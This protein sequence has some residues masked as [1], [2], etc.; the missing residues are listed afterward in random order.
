MHG[1]IEG[2]GYPFDQKSIA[3]HYLGWYAS[4]PF[5]I[6]I[7]TNNAMIYIERM[8]Y[9]KTSIE[10]MLMKIKS[11]NEGSLSNG[12]LMR[13]TPLAVY[14]YKLDN[15][16]IYEC[17]KKDVNLT[18]SNEV[19][20]QAVTAYNI[21]IAHLLNNFGDSEGA[22]EKAR[23]YVDSSNSTLLHEYWKAIDSAK[24]ESDLI[25]ATEN[26][27]FIMIAFSYA[28]FYLRQD[29][30]YKTVLAKTLLLGKTLRYLGL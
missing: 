28:F 25:P 27:G 19:A 30:D 29:Y 1:L 13:T 16:H 9:Y 17:T 24:D 15:Q 3:H 10:D 20:V 23:N 22:Y 8:F 4:H 2:T 11:K 18:H 14:C 26:I 7:T 6:G 5:D 21:A 12:G